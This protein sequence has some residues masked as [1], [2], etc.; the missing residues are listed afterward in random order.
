[1]ILFNCSGGL[2]FRYM[3]TAVF[4]LLFLLVITITFDFCS[5][6]VILLFSAHFVI[7][8]ISIFAKFSASIS[9]SAVTATRRSSAKAIALVLCVYVCVCMYVCIY[10]YVCVC[11]C[12]Y[13]GCNRGN[14]PDF[15]RVFLM[16]NYTEKTQNTYIRS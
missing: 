2:L 11:V 4:S 13:T 3:E 7:L 14:G 10:V 1:L 9:V 15:G 8:V 5:L 16:L 6:N 12:M